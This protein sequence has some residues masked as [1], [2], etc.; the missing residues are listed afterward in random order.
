MALRYCF[1][2]ENVKRTLDR[3]KKQDLAVVDTDGIPA[4]IIR[5]AINRGVYVYDYLNAGALEKERSF[6][7]KFKGLRLAAYD[8]W[9]G[10]YW[11]DVTDSAWQAHLIESARESKKKGAIGLYFDN[12]DIYWMCKEGFKE[13]GSSMLRKAP[14][15]DAVYKAL[16]NVITTI[17]M[18][19]GLIVMPNGADG[20]VRRMFAAGHGKALIRTINQEGCLYEDFKKQPK[21]ETAY[22]K[23]Y[24]KWASAHVKG[25]IRGIEYCKKPSEI[26]KVKAYYAAHG[27]DVYISKHKDL[28]GD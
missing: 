10:E 26:A 25:K 27:W 2:Q 1:E 6:Y 20:F 21:S 11:V 9:P 4:N 15:A 7:A 8:G 24:M 16:L 18:D 22:R 23:E 5:D 19:V 28:R 12:A 13:Q 17:V 14:S 3:C